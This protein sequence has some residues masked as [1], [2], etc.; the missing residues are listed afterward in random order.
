MSY[1]LDALRKAE[2]DRAPK[3]NSSEIDVEN[4]DWNAPPEKNPRN[5]I[6]F[7]I[8]A[9]I[10]L[11]IILLFLFN[12]FFIN[13]QAGSFNTEI[14]RSNVSNE[15]LGV[16]TELDIELDIEPDTVT[17]AVLLDN[18]L[19]T[20][21][22]N[23]QE[24]QVFDDVIPVNSLQSRID[25]LEFEGSLFSPS[26][27]SLSRIFISGASYRTGDSIENDLY[28]DGLYILD[29]Q[30]HIVVFSDGFDQLE[31]RIK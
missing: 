16:T 24:A 25:A 15:S 6:P 23:A 9:G 5:S 21:L 11:L 3:K 20:S 29:I 31:Y 14:E 2:Q 1:V 28:E 12:G 8:F 30:E 27:K 18:P 4:V 22:D 10:L 13:K 17:E 26:D 7:G 19:D